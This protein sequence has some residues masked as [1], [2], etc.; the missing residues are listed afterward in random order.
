ML[1]TKVR[2][3]MNAPRHSKSPRGWIIRDV[4]KDQNLGG[5]NVGTTAPPGKSAGSRLTQS[6][7]DAAAA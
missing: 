7:S 5:M 6:W 1:S 3:P 4:G 2:W